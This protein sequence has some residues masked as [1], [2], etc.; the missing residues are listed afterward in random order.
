M[1]KQSHLK[2]AHC[3]WKCLRYRRLKSGKL[4]SG[5]QSLIDHG[6]SAHGI[7]SEAAEAA[8]CMS[9]DNQRSLYR[10]EAKEFV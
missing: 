4:R 2:C 1:K 5:F 6:F 7:T 10:A 8:Y 9:E 3:E